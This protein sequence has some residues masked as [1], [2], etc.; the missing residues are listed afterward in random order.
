MA[1]TDEIDFCDLSPS[2]KLGFLHFKSFV[3]RHGEKA[4]RKFGVGAMRKNFG[5]D[6]PAPVVPINVALPANVVSIVEAQKARQRKRLAK[7]GIPVSTQNHRD[8]P[9]GKAVQEWRKALA[10]V[11]DECGACKWANRPA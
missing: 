8:T 2:V 4:C 9:E 3:E 7:A 11:C 1:R 10:A 5:H 6:D